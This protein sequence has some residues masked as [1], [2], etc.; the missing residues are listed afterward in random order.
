[1]ALAL[2]AQTARAQIYYDYVPSPSFTFDADGHYWDIVNPDASGS[3]YYSNLSGGS[4]NYGWPLLPYLWFIPGVPT[5]PANGENSYMG[6]DPTGPSGSNKGGLSVPVLIYVLP[7]QWTQGTTGPGFIPCTDIVIDDVNGTNVAICRFTDAVGDLDS[8]IPATE[9]IFYSRPGGGDLADTG[10][11]TQTHVTIGDEGYVSEGPNNEFFFAFGLY[12]APGEGY[13]QN[14]QFYGYIAYGLPVPRLLGSPA[15][16]GPV[17]NI[18]PQ[19][20]AVAAGSVATFTVQ[21]SGSPLWY[22]WLLNGTNP[23]GSNISWSPYSNTLVVNPTTTNDAG[24]Y[25]VIVSNPCGVVG[26]SVAVL[27]VTNPASTN[28][29]IISSQPQSLV[30]APGNPATFTVVASGTPPLSYQWQLN[31]TNL[32]GTNISGSSSSTLILNPVTATDAGSYW[33]IVSNACGSVTSS[34]GVLTVRV[35]GPNFWAIPFGGSDGQLP[36]AGLV[37]SGDT[38]YGTASRGGANGWGSVFAVKTN[39]TAISPLLSFGTGSAPN[40]PL[41]GL[42]LAGSTLYGTTAY[43]NAQLAGSVFKLNT[44]GGGYA[45][46]HLFPQSSQDGIGP[47]AGLILVG[48]TLYGTTGYGGANGLGSVF[49]INTSATGYTNLYSFSGSDGDVPKAGLVVSGGALYGT[50]AYGGSAGYGTVFKINTD[51]TGFTVLYSFTNGADGSEPVADLVLSG[52]TLYGTAMTGGTNGGGTVFQVNTDGTG[53]AVLHSFSG[54]DGALPSAGLV[55]LGGTL[56]G[57]TYYGGTTCTGPVKSGYGTVFQVNTDGTG[58]ATLY[59]FTGGMD[60]ADP[61]GDLLLSGN[62]FYGTTEW[63]GSANDGVV[64][65]LTIWVLP[66]PL[67]ITPWTGF[68]SVGGVGGP[69]SVTAQSL[70]LTNA[71]ANTL[72]WSLA[73]T[74]LWLN[75]S[76]TGGTLTPGG[77]ATTV[78]VSLNT[79]AS[80]LPVGTYSATLWFTNLTSKVGQSR[81]YSLSVISPP[82]ITTQPSDQAVPACAPATFSV[83]ATGTEPLSYQWQFNGTSLVDGGNVSGSTSDTL[84]LSVTTTNDQ[85]NYQVMVSNPAGTVTSRVAVLTVLMGTLP[86][87]KCNGP[88]IVSDPS[89]Q[90]P[91]PQ[92]IDV[93]ASA[94]TLYENVTVIPFSPCMTN[95]VYTWTYTNCCQQ[96]AS[97]ASTVTVLTATT[98]I[99]ITTTPS[100]TVGSGCTVTF[101]VPPWVGCQCSWTTN[102]VLLAPNGSPSIMTIAGIP[103]EQGFNGTN[104]FIVNGDN[105]TNVQLP[106][107]SA[108]LNSPGSVA[109]DSAFNVY[110]ADSGNHLVRMVGTD[111]NIYTFAGGGLVHPADL[112]EWPNSHHSPTDIRLHN[113]RR[114]EPTAVAADTNGNVYIAFYDMVLKAG[115]AV[116]T[117][118][119]GTHQTVETNFIIASWA[120]SYAGFNE[121]G[122]PLLRHPQGLALD[123]D[124]NL[125]FALT[126]GNCVLSET[127]NDTWRPARLV[128]GYKYDKI[129]VGYAGDGGP[130]TST[131]VMLCHPVGVAV[132][133][134]GNVYI[135]DTDNN[136]IREVAAS[137]GFISTY[138]GN[139][140][141]YPKAGY[142]GDG[143][144]ANSPNVLLSAP[145]SVVADAAGNLYIADTWNNVIRMV[146]TAG[147]ISTVVGGTP[148]TAYGPLGDGGPA[149]DASLSMPGG[150]AMDSCGNLY[151]ADTG[152][153]CIR[154][155]SKTMLTLTDLAPGTYTNVANVGTNSFTTVLTVTS[156]SGGGPP[157]Q[158]M[159]SWPSSSQADV[160]EGVSFAA[161]AV[162]EGPLHYQWQK[163]GMDLVDGGNIVGSTNPILSLTTTGTNDVAFYTAVVSD[164]SGNTVAV[165]PPAALSVVI[166]QPMILQEPADQTVTMEQSPQL[167]IGVI[168][169]TTNAYPIDCQWRHNYT[170]LPITTVAGGG[171]GPD[172]NLAVG[173]RL[174]GPGGTAFDGAGNLFIA[175]TVNNVIR[176]LDTNGVVSAFAGNG[177]SGFAGD[178]GAATNAQL[179]GPVAVAFDLLG[180]CLIA[181]KGNNRVRRVDTNGVITTVA[182]NGTNGFAGDGGPATGAELSEPVAVAV[183][184][185][186]DCFIADQGNNCIRR[187]DTYGM[188]T[189]VAGNG[190]NGFAGDGGVATSANLSLPSSVAVD[191]F[192][193]LL[194]ADQGNNRVRQ[195]APNGIISTVA[196]NGAEGFA[197]DGDYATNASLSLPSGVAVDV[198]GNLFIADHGNS[199]VRLVTTNGIITTVA[200][201]GIVTYAGDGG[202][203]TNASLD[204]AAVTVDDLG[205]VFVADTINNRIRRFTWPTSTGPAIINMMT[206]TLTIHYVTTNDACIYDVVVISPC[207]G[208]Y[209]PTLVEAVYGIAFTPD[210]PEVSDPATL[211][212]YVPPIISLEP[213]NQL[214]PVAGS[215]HFGITAYGTPPFS[216]QWQLNGTNLPTGIISTVAGNGGMGWAGDGGPATNAALFAPWGIAGDAAG[217]VYVADWGN[218]RVR[219]IS[220]TGIIT[221]VAGNGNWAYAGDGGPATNASLAGPEGVVV[222][223]AGN[224]FI[225]DTDNHVVREVSATSGLITT[226][227]GNA[228]RGY[229]G[230]GGPAT[231]AEL[232]NPYGVA[233]DATGN[234]FIAD[235]G[236]FRI[237]KVDTNGIITTVAGNGGTED[238]GDGGP[239]IN[240]GIDQP[241]GIAVD[242]WGNLFITDS[243]NYRVRMVDTNGIIT[244]VAGNGSYGYSGDGGPATNASLNWPWGVALHSPGT[245]FFA[246]TNSGFY[247][248]DGLANLQSPGTLFIADTYNQC[249]RRVDP[250]TPPPDCVTVVSAP[251]V[252]YDPNDYQI[253]STAAGMLNDPYGVALDDAGN[254]FIADTDS[255]RVCKVLLY[256]SYPTLGLD[257]VTTN[258]AGNYTVVVTSPY[259][260]ATS[261]VARLTVV[262]LPS[263]PQSLVVTNGGPASFSV[264][265]S[266]SGA[267][268]LFYQWQRN[269]TNLVD[270]GNISGSLTANLLLSTTTTNDAGSYDVVITCSYGNVTSTVASLA[271]ILPP[272]PTVQAVV[273]GSNV[274]F[275]ATVVGTGPFTY[276]WQLDGTNLPDIYGII[277]TVAGGG[278]NSPGNGGAATNASLRWPWGVAVDGSG[279]LFLTDERN[280]RL[281]KV[282]T[283]GIIWTVAGNGAQG[284]SGDGGPATSAEL[285]WPLGLALDASSNLFFADYKNS[286]VREIANGVIWTVAGNGVAG[287]SGDGGP[288]TSAELWGPAGVAVDASG[289]LFISDFDANVVRR[290]DTNGIITTVA[291]TG[292]LGYSGDGGP[293]TSASLTYPLGVA[294][295]NFGNLFIADSGNS[296]IRCVNSSGV[297][298][299]VAGSATNGIVWNM[300]GWIGASTFGDPDYVGPAT[301]ASLGYPG[302]VAVDGSGNLFIADSWNSRIR[303][304]NSQGIICTLAGDYLRGFAGDGGPATSASLNWPFGVALDTN[305]NLFIAD[306][307]NQRIREVQLNPNYPIATLPILTLYNVT[308]N[309][310]G[311]YTV[312]VTGPGGS[313]TSVIV[314]LIVTDPSLGQ[315]QV[316]VFSAPRISRLV[317]NADGSVTLNLLT[318][319]K[320]SSR[321]LMATTLTPPVVW[322]PICTNAPASDGAWQFT[323]TNAANN[324]ARFYRCSTP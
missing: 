115:Y 6:T 184:A 237:R 46:L 213:T 56:Y 121:E 239:A 278:P 246:D 33:V 125:Y 159:L 296:R 73:N 205:N 204:A 195:V 283:N 317:R 127:N 304:V 42:V 141:N 113:D 165:S 38:L 120:W 158:G 36:C 3:T 98:P 26:S 254:L 311:N 39:G 217:S 268:S 221:T 148:S 219:K 255:N 316:V 137:N 88:Y 50:T 200:G 272:Q 299:T 281:Y 182:G 61:D 197:G 162:G 191:A 248:P 90:P 305:G 114:S 291:G 318:A 261:S 155:V 136:V 32:T 253:I 273:A 60:G 292:N 284:F 14:I 265:A 119:S 236:N 92:I 173:V 156:G 306:T 66:E 81:Q 8:V 116:Q 22:Q 277:T 58:F 308:A 276:Q 238:T 295:D 124:N 257:G 256:A 271:I 251:P 65:A 163:N 234:L 286:R 20:V 101:Y 262:A 185:L 51:G 232:Y 9:M 243:E 290:V 77:P 206:N 233:L 176:C 313:V 144:P 181:D 130:A 240:A 23:T 25:R 17:I 160:E 74:S 169:F 171:V 303:I 112:H 180:N 207:S 1:L 75:A 63:G 7:S 104:E 190:T 72:T 247:V 172:G 170:N 307:Y 177:M 187:V 110:I 138:A 126:D 259:G 45:A 59:N 152:N 44:G 68:S 166:P 43:K 228:V 269:G 142:S 109:V 4:T 189:T 133:A 91:G 21:A 225:A 161:R 216:F 18:Q 129:R 315:P 199:L 5:P 78:T 266:A 40:L 35:V 54:G 28:C 94:G 293:A 19:S 223:S 146:D 13:Y 302:A 192:G 279:N 282:D 275:T 212:V 168:T 245:L 218:S 52:N 107:T 135:A 128:A 235:W 31:G 69:F 85:G 242:V 270:G 323:D 288:A 208:E 97:C 154:M 174:N 47:L 89:F 263:Q 300:T 231:N 134:S 249:I 48:N 324:S 105:S 86:T 258:D 321:I 118:G 188:I 108:K 209:D 12:Q 150:L 147:I 264:T 16:P 167:Q 210:P 122:W 179:S 64:F 215:A 57:T 244:T 241:S 220:A 49:A 84:V 229:S 82:M 298:S 285:Y 267:A 224:L 70:S 139:Y 227:A 211:T 294:A 193:N 297:I 222:D 83:G 178:G 203:P 27:R 260:C 164:S 319:P 287:Y 322:E 95:Y 175:D 103:V 30:V 93:C 151:I 201:N 140:N 320:T 314:S 214:S 149:A 37:L 99:N 10:L 194:I 53:F 87:L 96:T 183:D 100:I 15:C 157:I 301:N 62:T 226:V 252:S 111:G 11:P 274:T 186:G 76:P 250:Y 80:N 312:V 198:F 79:V 132:D 202:A 289:N 143:G 67:V 24:S 145:S 55:L 29:P 196:G 123:T 117:N 2:L 106:A 153:H 71:G 309:E 230:D 34:V 102:G 41:G 280:N 131:N 310:A